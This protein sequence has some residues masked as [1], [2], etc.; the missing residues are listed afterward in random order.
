MISGVPRLM[1]Q[2]I[3]QP[4]DVNNN[5]NENACSSSCH[6]RTLSQSRGSKNFPVQTF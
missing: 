3:R 4:T 6:I 5:N 1:V 2:P